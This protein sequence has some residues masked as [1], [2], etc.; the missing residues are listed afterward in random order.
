[1][2]QSTENKFLGEVKISQLLLKFSVPCILSL[3][4]SALYNIVD[5]IFIGNSELG[6]LGN[7][8]TGIV[9]PI[10]IITQAFAW[11]IGDGCAA[12]LSICQGKKDTL[13]SH[14]CIGSGITVTFIIS[15]I[16]LALGLIFK[17]PLLRLFGASDQT[18]GMSIDYFTIVCA[19]FPFFMLMNMMNAVIRADGS[20]NFSMASMSVG[21]V[22]NIILDPVFIFGFNWGIEGAA[23]A[24]VIG[25]VASFLISFIYFFR[26]KTFRLNKSSF[27]TDFRVFSNALRFG[28]SS[29]ITQMSIVI[30]SLV[31]N[32][33]LYKYG[34]MSVYGPDI[35]ISVISIETKVFTIVINIVVGI[36][37]GGQPIIGYN[38]GAKKY[39]RVKQTYKTIL[40]ATIIVGIISTLI[41]EIYP[42]LVI[43][44]FGA[45][46]EL[47]MEFAERTF[48]IFLSLVTFTCIIKMTS[49]FF[50]AVGKPVKAV[51]ASLTRDLVCFVP[52]VF[53]LPYFFEKNQAGNGI[54]GILFASPAAD[55]IAMIVAMILTVPF[56]KKLNK[57]SDLKADNNT[58]TIKPS[59]EGVIITIAREHGSQGKQIGKMVAEKLN[60]PFYY[61]ELTALAAQESGLSKEFISELNQN[62]P[63]V[64]HDLYLS[65]TV[66]QQAVVA[67]DRIIKKIADNGTC[68]IVG[69]AADYVLRDYENVV[70][71]FIYAPKDFRVSKV[72][73]MYGDT[74]TE[75]VSNIKRST[76]ARS[77]YYKNIS[78]LEWGNPHNY[79][80][81]IDSSVGLE[82]SVDVICNYVNGI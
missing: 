45:G 61:K 9:F 39:D 2:E 13:N 68:V 3:L 8:A 72:M 64:L 6:Y 17:E 32:I 27:I 70:K 57:A 20:P 65:T 77:A 38:Y 18:I 24:T 73:E 82:K 80:L 16:L 33:M 46:D 15:I 69:R 54:N 81:C 55:I 11:C 79:D 4:I 19:F 53:L 66:V 31:C 30:I 75:A 25:Q 52:L 47:Y 74:Q 10:L 35:P 67:Q 23:W 7:A 51:I 37:L 29:F 78:G 60:I 49:I 76:E 59:K 14:K 28:A 40:L 26:T 1:M 48:R 36:V 22:I 71:V 12:Y 63:K 41:F 58:E 44:I 34:E 21:A 42:Q 43:G 5:Q 56:F 50:Q 62:S